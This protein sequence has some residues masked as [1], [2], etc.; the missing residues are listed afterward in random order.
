MIKSKIKGD[1]SILS[2][3][4]RWGGGRAWDV[5][6]ANRPGPA[7]APRCPARSAAEGGAWGRGVAKGGRDTV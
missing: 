7:A 3:A 4:P 1:L 6:L 2:V 5:A